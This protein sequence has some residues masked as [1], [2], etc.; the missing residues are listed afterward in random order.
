[1]SSNTSLGRAEKGSKYWMQTLI[2]TEYV[3]TLNKAIQNED[4]SIG[5]I[6]WKSPLP[7]D[8]KE[9]KT[10]EID[11]LMKADLSFWPGHGPQWDAVGVDENGCVILVE[12][13]G[14]VNETHTKCTASSPNSIQKIKVSM[15][16]IHNKLAP[17]NR[18]NEK[19]WFSEYYQ[20]GNRL[21]FLNKLTEQG[22]KVKLVLLNIVKDPTH[23]KTC[24]E[25][26]TNHYKEVFEKMIG[27]EEA[28]KNAIVVNLKV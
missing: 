3:Q 11:E 7:D 20:M 28:P 6:E 22:F 15:K 1:M 10:N 26:W 14:H 9:F 19:A 12:A 25:K 8:Y 13:K 21:T 24:E 17:L 27:Q 16:E 4:N 18:Y 23:I 5:L 2:Q